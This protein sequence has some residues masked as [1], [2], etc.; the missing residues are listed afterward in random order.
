MFLSA[1]KAH[2]TLFLIFSI[3]LAVI[4]I[5]GCSKEDKNVIRDY[6]EPTPTL[7]YD[8]NT[9]ENFFATEDYASAAAGYDSFIKSHPLNDNVPYALF[10]QGLSYFKLSEDPR[11][12]QAP[13]EKAAE[14]FSQLILMYPNSKYI[15]S[16]MSYLRL[17]HERLAEYNFNVG[18]YYFERE[19]YNAAIIRFQDVITKYPGFGYDEDAKKYIEE[20]KKLLSEMK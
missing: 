10:R 20:S 11:K 1:K 5:A 4:L 13:T 2:T 18:M 6:G 17:C 16:A 14:K 3:A 12:D 8:L 19:E 15:S 7:D 9:A